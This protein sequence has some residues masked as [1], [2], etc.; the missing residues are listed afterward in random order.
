MILFLKYSFGHL[1]QEPLKVLILII[2][3]ALGVAVYGSIR[4]ANQAV[5]DQFENTTKDLAGPNSLQ[6]KSTIGWI[7]ETI[8]PLLRQHPSISSVTPRSSELAQVKSLGNSIGSVQVIGIDIL[9]KSNLTNADML[10]FDVET[11]SELL[12]GQA[13]IISKNLASKIASHDL[14]LIFEGQTLQFNKTLVL[15]QN[16]VSPNYIEDLVIIDIAIFQELFDS[17]GKVELFDLIPSSA[18]NQHKLETDLRPILPPASYLESSSQRQAQFSKLTESFRQNIS[19]LACISLLV[20]VLLIYNTLSFLGLKRLKEYGTLLAIGL[21]P[22]KLLILIL[23]ESMLLGVI[24][25]ALGIIGAILLSRYA[26][27]AVTTTVSTLYAQIQGPNLNV[28]LPLIFEF[29][30]IGL[31]TA[32]CGA[33]VPAL[34]AIK[35]PAKE[36]FYYQN[37]EQR[38][39]KH[40]RLYCFLGL[41]ALVLAY[42]FT[43]PKFIA[44]SAYAG[45]AS[46]TFACLAFLLICPYYTWL[47]STICQKLSKTLGLLE[48]TLALNHIRTQIS[49]NSAAVAS[50]ALALG[51]FFS[52]AITISSFRASVATWLTTVIKA[53][54]FISMPSSRSNLSQHYLPSNLD[55]FLLAQP[56]TLAINKTSTIQ[57]PFGE[58][59][60]YFTSQDFKV[61]A[62]KATLQIIGPQANLPLE[63]LLTPQAILISEALAYKFKY[64]VGDNFKLNLPAGTLSGTIKAIFK[65]YVTEHGSVLIDF[66]RFSE[67][68]G[69]ARPQGI[70]LYL[71]PTTNIT[72]L[73]ELIAANFPSRNFL[74]RDNAGL[75]SEVFKVFD[76][77]FSITTVLQAISLIIAIFVLVNSLL[78]LFLERQSEFTTFRA[79]GASSRT[80]LKMICYEGLLLILFAVIWALL[81]GLILGLILVFAVNQHFFGWSSMLVIPY[82]TILTTIILSIILA[83][84]A[85]IVVTVTTVYYV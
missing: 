61:T 29:C 13:A 47:A 66:Q 40:L 64:K 8:Y 76:N 41:I 75:R 48:P 46:P 35:A 14:T 57:V 18:T 26:V 31:I 85:S 53:D 6:L 9:A 55:S 28:E 68:T 22:Q 16:A 70:S 10:N 33:I 37:Y 39:F 49:R 24:G 82:T 3:I 25:T 45:F 71:S 77:T 59:L 30:L 67:L 79:I 62:A 42:I 43:L 20:A 38:A 4:I 1:K 73:S 63:A 21:R 56:A 7:D 72:K 78:M 36:T 11:T 32:I 44:A 83:I 81:I 84:L 15:N 69:L 12:K 51:M 60:I 80:L 5:L 23:L 58:R 52:V 65:D 34:T 17:F 27:L 54:L 19:F 2:G 74:I 50:I